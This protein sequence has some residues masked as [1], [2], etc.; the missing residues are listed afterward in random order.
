MA[1]VSR[2]DSDAE[3]EPPWVAPH[4]ERLRAAH[5]GAVQA[6]LDDH[7]GRLDWSAEQIRRHRDH[8]LR[9]LLAYAHERS[10]FYAERLSGLDVDAMTAADLASI[11]MLD[12]GGGASAV[13]CDRHDAG[14]ESSSS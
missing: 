14:A 5:L 11:P 4:T 13:G 10:P 1:P 9:S 12:E 8:R 6:A 3:E 7:V 2:P